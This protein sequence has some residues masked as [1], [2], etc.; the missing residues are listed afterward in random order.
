MKTRFLAT[1]IATLSITQLNCGAATP[2]IASVDAGD[3]AVSRDPQA[4]YLQLKDLTFKELMTGLS[5]APV[6][7]DPNVGAHDTLVRL[8]AGASLPSH[9]YTNAQNGFLLDGVL[10]Q[11][12]PSN[13]SNVV[14]MTAGSAFYFPAKAEHTSRCAA[15][16]DC[17]FLVHQDAAFDFVPNTV[18]V[19]ADKVPQNPDAKFVL[20][21]SL[22]YDVVMAGAVEM[23]TVRGDR[24]TGAHNTVIRVAA[25]AALPS[26]YYTNEMRGI[27][28]TGPLE[29]PAPAN[30]SAPASLVLGSFFKFAAKLPHGTTCR[31]TT[32]CIFYVH[33]PGP[34]DLVTTE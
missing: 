25:G 1:L 18:P 4:S 19:A 17:L 6:S 16:K 8:V 23:S 21:S 3:A 29:Q 15:G 28:L 20:P 30:E 34:F 24:A 13:Q 32:P 11:P 22:V 33:Q 26:H 7:G 12:T 10:E 5:I 2:T 27:V 31:A 14:T 9:F